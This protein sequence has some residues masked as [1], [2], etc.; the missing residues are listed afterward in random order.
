MMTK[1]AL[2]TEYLNKRK[3]LTEAERNKQDDLLLIQLQRVPLL[4]TQ[5]L[6]NYVPMAEM[7]EPNTYFLAQY[8]EAIIPGLVTAYPITNLK[9]STMEAFIADENTPFEKN[10]FGLV[11]PLSTLKM[12]PEAI[13]V[14]F[15]PLLIADLQGYRVGFGKG[16]YDK[17]LKTCRT[18]TLKIGFSYFEPVSEISDINKNDIPLDIIIT[19]YQIFE[20]LKK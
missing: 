19:P 12:D 4:N 17:Y 9:E 7:A 15:T 20:F 11:E 16:I 18:D 13:D 6:F 1:Q 8:L 2:R 14:V 5:T 10:R 3:A